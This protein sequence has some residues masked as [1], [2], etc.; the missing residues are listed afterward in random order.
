MS[1]YT[2]P[3]ELAVFLSEKDYTK[4]ALKRRIRETIGNFVID[5][6]ILYSIG[7]ALLTMLTLPI[8]LSTIALSFKLLGGC[9]AF[10]IIVTWLYSAWWIHTDDE[11]KWYAF[12]EKVAA[13]VKKSDSPV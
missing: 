10:T 7:G 8:L 3:G 9:I 13:W 5:F 2:S 12:C 4:K 6:V 11:S 1:D